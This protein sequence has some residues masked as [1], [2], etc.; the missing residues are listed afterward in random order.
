FPNVADWL[1]ANEKPLAMVREALQRPDYYNP[2]VSSHPGTGP[3]GLMGAL[4]SSVQKCREIA[5][6]LTARAMLRTAEGKYDEAWQDLLA[7]HRLGRLVARGGTIIEALVGIAVDQVA[8][9]ADI[10]FLAHAKVDAKRL[11]LCRK[12]LEALPPLP[13]V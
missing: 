9:T 8:A 10:A 5:A 11:H 7:C 12:D 13:P 1:A 2:L 3:G 6:A 4:L